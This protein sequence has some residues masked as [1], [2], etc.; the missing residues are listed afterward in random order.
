M[1]FSATSF[2]F[3]YEPRNWGGFMD[4]NKRPVLVFN[5]R[6]TGLRSVYLDIAFVVYGKV[7]VNDFMVIVMEMFLFVIAGFYD[8][9]Y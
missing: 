7:D 4:C 3:S 1:G 9:N 8:S 5:C 2:I 6:E